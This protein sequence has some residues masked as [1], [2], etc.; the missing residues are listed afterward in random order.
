MM[1]AV[2]EY[3]EKQPSPQQEICRALRSIILKTFPDIKEEMGYGVPTYGEK[4]YIVG[5][6]D[7]VNLGFAI[8][9]LS[10]E[11]IALFEGTGKTMRNIKVRSLEDID[12]ARIVK[13]LKLVMERRP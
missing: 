10:R 6:K 7:S 11:E 3:F 9:G 2:D 12:E 8:T 4:Y 13:L 5:L 1:A